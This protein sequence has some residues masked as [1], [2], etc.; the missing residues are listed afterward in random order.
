MSRGQ[1]FSRKKKYIHTYAVISKKKDD[2]TTDVSIYEDSRRDFKDA[3]AL[4]ILK[5]SQIV[6]SLSLHS[7]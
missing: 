1:N 5:L 3:D 6:K 7:Q 2:T 4:D